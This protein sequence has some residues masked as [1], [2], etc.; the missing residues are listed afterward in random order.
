MGNSNT[1]ERPTIKDVSRLAGVSVAT[2]SAV[3]NS[4]PGVSQKLTQQVRRAIAALDYQPDI[5]ARSLRMQRSHVLGVVVPQF[6]SPFYAEVLRG[7][8][9][10]ATPQGYSILISNSRGNVA[11]ERDEVSMLI[12]RRV[13]GVLLATA[14]DHYVYQRIFPQNFPVVL[15]DRFPLGFAGAAVVTD[16]SQASFDATEHLIGLGHHRIAIIAGSP[17]IYTADERVEGFRNAMS[18]AGLIVPPEYTRRGNFLMEGGWKC[19]LELLQLPTPPTAIFSHNYEMTLGLMRALGERGVRC[20]EQISVLG[21]DDFV[22]GM[23]GFS[24]ATLFSPKLTCVAQPSYEL[25]RHAAEVLLEKVKKHPDEAYSEEGIIRM[26]AELRI[27]QST[28]PPP[29]A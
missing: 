14:F 4:R 17:G 12:S 20:P 1:P 13:D 15:F 26:S 7:I 18:R 19:G 6:A 28:A 25:G 10:I 29:K 22:V 11:Q 27:R 2:V 21:F 24:W 16:N 5:L 9:D 23:D 3:I 8:E